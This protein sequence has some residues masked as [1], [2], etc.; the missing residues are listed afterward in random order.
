MNGKTAKMKTSIKNLMLPHFALL[1]LFLGCGDYSDLRLRHDCER[2]FY[3]ASSELE[4]RYLL[5]TGTDFVIEEEV[6][7]GFRKVVDRFWREELA[8]DIPALSQAQKQAWYLTAKAHLKI[9]EL[10]SQNKDYLRADNELRKIPDSYPLNPYQSALALYYCGAIAELQRDYRKA[11]ND[12]QRILDDYRP[13]LEDQKTPE[14]LLVG[15]PIL[16]AEVFRKKGE[17]ENYREELDKARSY[18]RRLYNENP[19]ALLAAAA[20]GKIASTYLLESL[21]SKAIETLSEL[22]DEQGRFPSAVMLRIAQIYL[23]HARDYRAAESAFSRYLN[24]YP[25][26]DE[27]VLAQLGLGLSLFHQREYKKATN[28]F[29]SVE[30]NYPRKWQQ[31]SKA[32]FLYAQCFEKMGDW[33]RALTEF[34]WVK[35]NFPATLEGL[36]VP[37][38]IAQHY[39][40][41]GEKRLAED[42]FE[43]GIEFYRKTVDTY[44]KTSIAPIAQ[45]YVAKSLLALGRWRE[46][47]ESFKALAER[48][49]GSR[50]AS[51]S[52]LAAADIYRVKLN[53]KTS[54]ANSLREYL[55]RFPHYPQAE[56]LR[57]EIESLEA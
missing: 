57:E 52:L 31:I 10:Y 51:A 8:A 33:Q 48:F 20:L 23:D 5:Q 32:H 26:S 50:L 4:Q 54:A 7:E 46:A 45:N 11:L 42:S 13:T 14:P 35:I 1:L 44:S 18:Y 16:R 36:E 3:F 12:Y 47:A 24:L 22:K 25:D 53:D 39:E 43:K 28:E 41:S 30:K 49:P 40:R 15:V 6:I 37:Y 21:P 34:N 2:L 9:G 19:K 55:E 29:L 27:A 38:Y 56:E 17:S